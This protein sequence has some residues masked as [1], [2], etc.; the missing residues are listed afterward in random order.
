MS[1]PNLARRSDQE[2]QIVNQH[3]TLMHKIIIVRE[4]LHNAL[5]ALAPALGTDP[6]HPELQRM[7]VEYNAPRQVLDLVTTDGA[8]MHVVTIDAPSGDRETSYSYELPADDLLALVKASKPKKAPV[9]AT[10]DQDGIHYAGRTYAA[11]RDWGFPPWRKVVPN[12]QIV[13]TT[14]M[15]AD[16]LAVFANA[17]C[18]VAYEGKIFR[19]NTALALAY[20]TLSNTLRA[21]VLCDES[22]GDQYPAQEVNLSF[23][24]DA[25]RAS[26]HTCTIQ[27]GSHPH[28]TIIITAQIGWASAMTLKCYIAPLLG[29]RKTKAKRKA[30]P[31]AKRT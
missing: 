16:T 15:D 29:E 1:T 21:D 8:R 28:D 26:L 18:S 7:R 13:S 3:L 14:R 31:K 20:E 24:A 6:A 22:F 9:E 5:A 30:K 27:Q 10:I 25:A 23:I 19:T 12:H 11:N 4:N 2:P 17:L